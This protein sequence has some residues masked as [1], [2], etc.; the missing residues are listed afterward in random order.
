MAETHNKKCLNESP[1]LSP[2]APL[3]LLDGNM[4]FE[5]QQML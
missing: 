2:P 4:H 1:A 5:K 3:K